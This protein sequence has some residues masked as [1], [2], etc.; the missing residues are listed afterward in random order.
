MHK[1]KR[2]G[3]TG[4]DIA[5]LAVVVG[6]GIYVISQLPKW[7]SLSTGT[8]ANNASVDQANQQG[9]ASTLATLQASGIQPTIS[10]AQAANIANLL[11]S[12]PQAASSASDPTVYSNIQAQLALLNNDYDFLMVQQKFGTKLMNPGGWWARHLSDCYWLGTNC[13]SE[14]L[15]SFL[16]MIASQDPTGNALSAWN[17]QLADNDITIRI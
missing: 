14:D 9:T 6:G 8:Q 13:V 4:T 17:Q 2:V 16:S 12:L 15:T 5:I 1:R 7:L 3:S 11:Y 10:V